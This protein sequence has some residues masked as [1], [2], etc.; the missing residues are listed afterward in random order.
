LNI[1]QSTF[2]YENIK[3]IAYS[4]SAQVGIGTSTPTVP[5]DIEAADAAIDI[6]NTSTDP[7]IHF[8]VS[9]TTH[10]TIGTDV[11]DSKF[12][13]GTTA[14]ETGT[15]VTVQSTGEV[16]IGTT[17]PTATLDVDGSAIFNESGNSVD[18][19]VEGDTK[20]N[21]LFVDGSADKVG[22]GTSSPSTTLDV[23]GAV[24][25]KGS[26]SASSEALLELKAPYS[27]LRL[28]DTDDASYFHCTQSGGKLS[29]RYNSTSATPLFYLNGTS[30]E[31]GIGTTDPN[32]TLDVRGTIGN[33]ATTHHS[34]K[35]WKKN[36]DSIENPLQK[37]L[38]VEGKKI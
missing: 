30:S 19:R 9:G 37:I 10:F 13:I 20:A 35:R 16:G 8:Q 27:Q 29:F 4:A 22:I 1:E 38:M 26:I 14:L 32:Y 12:K 33:N 3:Y 18:F 7:L 34:D 36:I 11:T 24:L 17:T 21:L 23:G 2:C 31:V 6:N 15:S 25:A 28:T 5:L